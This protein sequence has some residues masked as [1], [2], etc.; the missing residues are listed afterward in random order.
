ML[1][2]ESGSSGSW[3]ESDKLRATLAGIH[4][5][6]QGGSK[7]WKLV[8]TLKIKRKNNDFEVDTGAEL[9]TIPATLYRPKL[10]QVRLEPSSH[11]APV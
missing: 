5:V 10:N 8:M 4:K 7:P 9:S 2:A 1:E 6:A 3:D 11:P